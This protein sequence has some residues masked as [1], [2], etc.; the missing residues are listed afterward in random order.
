[1]NINLAEKKYLLFIISDGAVITHISETIT[2]NP[3]ENATLECTMVGM[4]VEERHI[5]WERVSD[6]GYDIDSRTTTTFTNASAPTAKLYLHIKNPQ[7]EDV[8]SF[9]CVVNNRYAK[10]NPN[11]REVLFIVNCELNFYI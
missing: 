4:P 5:R 1:M 11:S 10:T 6:P 9:R 2:V 3:G 7:R 8:G